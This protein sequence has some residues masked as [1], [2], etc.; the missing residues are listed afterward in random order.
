MKMDY[1]YWLNLS[2]ILFLIIII[3]LMIRDYGEYLK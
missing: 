1:E 3:G 2:M